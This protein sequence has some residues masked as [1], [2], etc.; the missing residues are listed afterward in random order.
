MMEVL[1]S[2][3]SRSDFGVN[4]PVRVWAWNAAL[5]LVCGNSVVWKPS[6][7]NR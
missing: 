3:V 4:F 2:L 5:A 7:K 6:E 1:A